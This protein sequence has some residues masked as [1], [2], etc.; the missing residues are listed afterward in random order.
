MTTE[1]G[2]PSGQSEAGLYELAMRSL[3]DTVVLT[4]EA[5]AIEWVCPNVEHIFGRSDD[6]LLGEPIDRLLGPGNTPSELGGETSNRSVVTT[7]A[8]GET[9]YLLVTTTPVEGGGRSYLYACRDVTERH[10]LRR[11]LD[12][13]LERL[14]DAVFTVDRE[15]RIEY[16]NGR[17]AAWI[18]RDRDEVVG[19]S[20]WDVVDDAESLDSYEILQRALETGEVTTYERY[21]EDLDT[22]FE[23]TA[24]PSE[25]GLSVYSRD[26]TERRRTE[27]KRAEAERR[28]E[29][30]FEGTL[31]ALVLADEDGTYLDVNPAACELY[32]LSHDELLGK[33]AGDFAPEGFDF[34]AAWAMFLGEGEMHGEFELVRPDGEVRVTDF[35]ATKIR[36]GE[37]LSALRDVT[38]RKEKEAA[39]RASERRYR[40][41]FEQ[42]PSAVVVADDEG[43]YVDANPAATELFGCP[44]AELVGRHISEFTSERYDFEAGWQA[45]LE[46]GEFRGQFDIVRAQGDV[47]ITEATSIANVTPGEHLAVFRDVSEQ[48]TRERTLETQ[49][50][51]LVHLQ[52]VN[53]LVREV[54]RSIVG[55]TGRE[56]VLRKACD[57]AGSSE[58]YEGAAVATMTSGVN[59]MAACN[60]DERWL[61]ESPT[62]TEAVAAAYAGRG[63]QTVTDVRTT[64]DGT[65]EVTLELFSLDYD[66]TVYGVL[67]VLTPDRDS[68]GADERS[69]LAEL[70]RTVGKAVAAIASQQLLH[71]ERATRLTLTVDTDLY[72]DLAAHGTSVEL[73]ELV[74]LGAHRQGHYLWMRGDETGSA[75]EAAM[76][77]PGVESCRVIRAQGDERLVE[78]VVRGRS[79]AAALFEQGAHVVEATASEG[80]CSLTVDV[81]ADADVRGLLERL[82][83]DFPETR[84]VSKYG[85]TGRQKELPTGRSA[86]APDCRLDLTE[87]QDAVLRAAYA[88]GFFEWPRRGTSAA[89][90]AE[91]FDIAPATL[92]QHLR[93]ATGKVV[94]ACLEY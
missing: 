20:L 86:A 31:D 53:E 57:C 80:S 69:L 66:G 10:D 59:V 50:D 93:Q 33:T 83:G 54:N 90:L 74:P 47:R 16:L 5:G 42:T 67:A 12:E 21:H 17:M 64:D 41:L 62:I 73:E 65:E 75:V 43:R 1:R 78:V 3:P 6:G 51:R 30:T 71:S 52:R 38:E 91:S 14:T 94:G 55:A 76:S 27:R 46:A 48:V 18:D 70:G 26:V 88:A 15:F 19:E 39:L 81:P 9:H 24:Y 29:A 36:D 68:F 8:D 35:A 37:Y 11:E 13:S 87:R 82:R 25:S 63:P 84:L 77:T 92:H 61:R 44:R 2:T 72:A 60:V 23:I 34:D 45:F 40:T 7:D 49:A 4:D 79:A 28:F 58:L 32:G 89:E 85:V 22:W 56:E